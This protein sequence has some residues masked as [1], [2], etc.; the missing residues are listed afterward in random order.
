M[1]ETIKKGGGK[2]TQIEK[3]TVSITFSSIHLES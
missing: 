2:C 3:I 1:K